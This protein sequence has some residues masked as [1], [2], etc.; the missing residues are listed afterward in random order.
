MTDHTSELVTPAHQQGYCN[1]E[2]IDLPSAAALIYLAL[3]LLL[4]FLKWFSAVSATAY[5]LALL[6]LL[7]GVL[8]NLFY[9][10]YPFPPASTIISAATIAFGVSTFTGGAHFFAAPFDWFIRDA[11]YADLI[12]TPWPTGD[13]DAST[14]V[15]YYLRSATGYFLPPAAVSSIIGIEHA[16][17]VLFLWTAIG[18]HLFLLIIAPPELRLPKKIAFWLIVILFSGMDILGFI[19]KQGEW[20][21]FPTRLEWWSSISYSS[22]P[23][24]LIWAPNHALPIWIAMAIILRH[25][26]KPHAVRLL[27]LLF[28]STAAWSPFAPLAVLPFAF[29]STFRHI[30]IFLKPTIAIQAIVAACLA[31]PLISFMAIGSFGT[32]GDDSAAT[33]LVQ[34]IPTRVTAMASVLEYSLFCLM[35]FAALAVVLAIHDFKQRRLLAASAILLGAIPLIP[36]LGPSNDL[37]LRLSIGALIVL[38]YTAAKA[39]LGAESFSPQRKSNTV[40]IL[41][42]LALGLP[43]VGYEFGRAL[44]VKNWPTNYETTLKEM[45]RGEL[46][47]HYF[48]AA[49]KAPT[50][51]NLKPPNITARQKNKPSLPH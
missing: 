1:D 48:G 30:R 47:G 31:V 32:N 4:F 6:V 14:G 20:P 28:L 50:W 51:L 36:S 39:V 7:A 2:Q 5:S 35:E 19:A 33:A 44:V 27:P 42:I 16:R 25:W 43:T 12:L 37:A 24:Q 8:R 11:V 23:A 49:N 34:N 9:F 40:F 41:V 38:A 45:L 21:D 22:L 17:W 3:P 26:Q 46:P 10:G 18:V 15:V 13:V 29:L